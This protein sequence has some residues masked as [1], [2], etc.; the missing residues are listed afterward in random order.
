[1]CEGG[2]PGSV[3]R[4]LIHRAADLCLGCWFEAAGFLCKVFKVQLHVVQHGSTLAL[5]ARAMSCGF[6][7]VF[8]VVL[9][10]LLT[11]SLGLITCWCL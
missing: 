1:M 11:K 3:E 6:T 10:L 8:L 7:H 9:M 2:Q 5:C 4:W